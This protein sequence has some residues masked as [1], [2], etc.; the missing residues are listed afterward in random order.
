MKK[1]IFILGVAFISLTSCTKK[2]EEKTVV[3]QEEMEKPETESAKECYQ[4]VSKKDTVMVTLITSNGNNITGDLKYKWFEKDNN[5]GK[6]S[7]MFKGDTLYADYTFQSEGMSS[8]REMVFLR[9]GNTLIEGFGDIEEKG[10]KQVF[11]DKK[12]LKFD[13]NIVLE[14]V[15]CK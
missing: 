12:N 14:K 5:D 8:V 1:S 13:A 15:I 3:T 6:I 10:D 4:Y 2:A 7:G 11:K 9:K